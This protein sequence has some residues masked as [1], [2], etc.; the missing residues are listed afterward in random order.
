MRLPE[1]E[2]RQ[3]YCDA[4]LLDFVEHPRCARVA[5]RSLTLRP[6]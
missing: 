6:D 1:G 4:E 2:S 5:Q 3:E